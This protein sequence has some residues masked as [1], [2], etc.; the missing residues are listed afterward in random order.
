MAQ[1]LD[2]TVNF[3]LGHHWRRHWNST[4]L[5]ATLSG[6]SHHSITQLTTMTTLQH[7]T[8]PTNYTIH[9]THMHVAGQLHT[10]I[11]IAQV[12]T[13]TLSSDT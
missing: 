6:P 2:S 12:Y 4:G 13:T 10:H 5:E 1:E 9:T 3:T 8:T 7:S 11:I